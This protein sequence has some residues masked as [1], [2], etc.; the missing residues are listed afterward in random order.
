[1]TAKADNSKVFWI[2]FWITIVVLAGLYIGAS[3]QRE[4]VIID[5]TGQ[6]TITKPYVAEW[7]QEVLPEFLSDIDIE[8]LN[9]KKDVKTVIEKRLDHAFAPVYKQIPKVADFHYSVTGEYLELMAAGS[10]E[11]G[12]DINRLLFEET[13]FNIRINQAMNFIYDDNTSIIARTLETLRNRLQEYAGFNAI[14]MG[15]IG[16]VATL[17]LEDAQSR[18]TTGFN[19]IRGAGS[20]VG[21]SAVAAILTKTIGQKVAGK[22]VVKMGSKAAAKAAGVGG[23]A[24]TGAAVGSVLGPIGT[25]VGGV[26]GGAVF[27]LATDKLIVEIDE[28]INRESFIAEITELVDAEKHR[29]RDQLLDLYFS[30]LNT[31]ADENKKSLKSIKMD[32]TRD[33]IEGN[34]MP[35]EPDKQNKQ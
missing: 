25:V 35:L 22:L 3:V 13:N 18:F 12:R 14:E 26:V 30:H 8:I 28:H 2:A 7:Q 6:I 9:A 10:G 5:K 33:L 19:V 11:V 21:A 24:A 29:I 15:L 1:M 31:I 16:D 27:W 34:T 17:T 20:M 32:T 23:G 4:K